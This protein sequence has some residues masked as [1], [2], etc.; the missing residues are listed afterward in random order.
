MGSSRSIHNQVFSLCSFSSPLSFFSILSQSQIPYHKYNLGCTNTNR[1]KL[2]LADRPS[3]FS[4][5]FLH[6]YN[7]FRNNDSDVGK[8]RIPVVVAASEGED[9]RKSYGHKA[10]VGTK[11]YCIYIDRCKCKHI[12]K[13]FQGYSK[14]TM[15]S[16][17][18]SHG[19][20]FSTQLRHLHLSIINRQGKK[21]EKITATE[22]VVNVEEEEEE[23]ENIYVNAEQTKLLFPVPW[24][25]LNFNFTKSSGPGGQNVNK[26]NTKVELRLAIDSESWLP[27]P[28]KERLKGQQASRI[29]SKYF[30]MFFVS[31]ISKNVFKQNICIYVIGNSTYSMA[32]KHK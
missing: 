21:N 9:Q 29:N 10:S 18:D 15:A 17:V 7:R 6:Y 30:Q 20:Y 31:F 13:S 19:E 14:A 2:A 11:D 16:I 28:V 12:Y 5:S 3:V 22:N 26:V 8:C 24:D 1:T 23:E 25:D 4:V 32:I 27:R